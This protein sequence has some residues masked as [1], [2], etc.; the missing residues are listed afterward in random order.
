MFVF[1]HKHITQEEKRNAIYRHLYE[2]NIKQLIREQKVIT[3]VW[4]E[5]CYETAAADVRD[6]VIS[7]NLDNYYNRLIKGI[8]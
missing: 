7:G 6:I 3:D 8:V 4:K 2:M 1:M 5:I